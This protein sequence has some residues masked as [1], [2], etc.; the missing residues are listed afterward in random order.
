MLI[1]PPLREPRQVLVDLAR[2]GMEDVRPV[3]VHEHARL[4]G[5]IVGIARDMRPAIADQH[6]LARIAREAFSEHTSGVARANNQVVVH[7]NESADLSRS[8]ADKL[9]DRE[10][11]DSETYGAALQSDAA[12]RADAC[13]LNRGF[14]CGAVNP[15][16]RG[17]RTDSRRRPAG[18][19][20]I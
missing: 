15:G 9:A 1:R 10:Q 16:R 6:L 12:S 17:E 11:L 5:M 2:I 18:S 19:D 8:R 7:V 14:Y 20:L 3:L 4:I 13:A